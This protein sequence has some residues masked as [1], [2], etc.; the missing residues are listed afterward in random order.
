MV[1]EGALHVGDPRR[2]HRAVRETAVEATV[3]FDVGS[4]ARRGV[5]G[6]TAARLATDLGAAEQGSGTDEVHGR[7]LTTQRLGAL[8]QATAVRLRDAHGLH[9][10]LLDDDLSPFIGGLRAGSAAVPIGTFRHAQ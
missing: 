8:A 6:A 2:G 5:F 7:D 10:A 1:V 9:S 4:V 3:E